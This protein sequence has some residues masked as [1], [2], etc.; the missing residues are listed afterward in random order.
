MKSDIKFNNLLDVAKRFPTEESCREYLEQIRWNGKPVCVHCGNTEKI[1]RIKNNTLLKCSACKK[2]FSVKVGTIFEDSHIELQK[3]FFAM[4]IHSAHKK[5]ISSCQLAKDIT[6]TQKTAWF[7]L[8]RIRLA[9][10]TKSFMKPLSG[11][12]EADETYVGGKYAGKRGRGS[13][14]KTPVFGLVERKGDVRTQPVK[15]VNKETL[16]GIIRDS[17][18]PA[19]TIMTDE[20]LAYRGLS[21]TYTHKVINHGK[22]EY[23]NG[24]I[25]V[26]TMENF[27][28]LLKRGIFG[29]YH[30]VSDKHLYRYCNEFGF[31]HNSR[32]ITDANRFEITVSQSEGKRLMYK[33][34]IGK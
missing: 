1:Y 11:I 5:G 16:Q 30:H 25:H 3:W 10:E 6:V 21:D 8:Q 17:V 15:R 13:E 23:A 31:R 18:V 27:W 26:N 9:M 32:E 22:K 33:N 7:M 2:N 28:S 20:W 29:I 14:N 24:N 12:V 34:L 19:T 4:F